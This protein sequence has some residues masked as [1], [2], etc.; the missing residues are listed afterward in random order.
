MLELII[1]IVTVAVLVT[2]AF[3]LLDYIG[4][5]EPINKIAKVLV[6]LVAVIYLLNIFAPILRIN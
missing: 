6:I 2:L 5:P 1:A 4:V 3:I